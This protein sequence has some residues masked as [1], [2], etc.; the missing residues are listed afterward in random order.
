MQHH[1]DALQH[2]HEYYPPR[3][4]AS[5]LLKR[6]DRIDHIGDSPPKATSR[7]RWDFRRK[8]PVLHCR[9]TAPQMQSCNSTAMWLNRSSISPSRSGAKLLSHRPSNARG[10]DSD[11][12]GCPLGVSGLGPR[13]CIQSGCEPLGFNRPSDVC[14]VCATHVSP[15][16]AR[17]V[18]TLRRARARR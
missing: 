17:P 11:P 15:R 8:C 7:H 18:V 14:S 13:S 1:Y 4:A 6:N 5:F 3:S 12:R 10:P 9:I 16:I 2:H